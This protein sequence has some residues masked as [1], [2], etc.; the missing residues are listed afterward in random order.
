MP[1][2][3]RAVSCSLLLIGLLSSY[4]VAEESSHLTRPA[5]LKPG[6]TIMFIAPAGSLDRKRIALAKKRLEERGYKIKMRDDVFASSGY[7]GG[8]DERRAEELMQAFCDPEV[9]A[10][11]PGTGGYGTT[12]ILDMLDFEVIRKNPKLFIG[13]SDI[14]ALHAAFN[15]LGGFV[16]YH[17]PAPM[18]SL[19]GDKPMMPFTEKYFFRAVEQNAENAQDYVIECIGDDKNK[20]PQ[21]V[22]LGKGKARGRLTG[23]NLSLLAAIE[24]TPHAI[25][26]RDAILLVED[27]GEAPYRIDRMLQQLKSAG[28]FDG[29]RGVVAGQFTETE[30]VPSKA[31]QYIA[32]FEKYFKKLGR[33][34]LRLFIK[35][36]E[37][38]ERVTDPRF[39]AEGVLRQ[40]FEPLGVPVLLN[41]PI[42]HYK[43]NC[44]LPLGGEVEID[45][46][47]ATLTVIGVKH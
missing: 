22:A 24:G 46:D 21:P 5:L 44:S 20:V 45:A 13:F 32:I 19:G 3:L 31:D 16:T 25:D 4:V 35:V 47:Q 27:V 36:E 15:K 14:T 43:M 18:Y 34:C 1:A 10:I 23:G 42:G 39:T 29:L 40:Y 11:F 41:F 12:R 30:R 9:D 8:S 26:T 28:R 6:D 17:T 37:P 33:D 2:M 7:L 38:K